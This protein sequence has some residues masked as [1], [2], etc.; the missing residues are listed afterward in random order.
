M[1]A[2]KQRNFLSMRIR[3]CPI[4]DLIVEAAFMTPGMSQLIMSGE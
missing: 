2:S 4:I 1:S 3:K